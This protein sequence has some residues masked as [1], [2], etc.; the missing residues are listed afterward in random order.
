[1]PSTPV[2]GTFWQT[3]QPVSIATMPTTPVTGTFYQATQPVSVAST[4]SV[5]DAGNAT[6][7]VASVSASITT[8]TL[9]AANSARKGLAINNDSA[10][11]LYL[12]LGATAS[13]ASYT[14]KMAANSYFE[15]PYNYTGVVDGIWV[16]ATGSALVTEVS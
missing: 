5:S 4:I 1:M 2:T 15:C 10:S 6:S 12:K 14:V 3:T 7:A 9:K 11:V 16:S 8:V 13:T